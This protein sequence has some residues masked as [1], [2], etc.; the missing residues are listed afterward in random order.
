MQ[1][2]DVFEGGLKNTNVSTISIEDEEDIEPTI[3]EIVV[4]N[5]KPCKPL[6][7]T[8]DRKSKRKTAKIA[9]RR[10]RS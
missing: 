3:E 2:V 6:K 8:I 4:K 9:R 7:K 1:K 10:N 5:W